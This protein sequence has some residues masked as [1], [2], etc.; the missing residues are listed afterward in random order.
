MVNLLKPKDLQMIKKLTLASIATIALLV[1]PAQ[2]EGMKCQA[3]KCG[4]GMMEKSKPKADCQG[5]N[6]Q[7]NGK[8]CKKGMKGMGSP[9]LL[10]L[11]SAM[12]WIEEFKD[13]ATLALSAEQKTKLE[14]QRNE[15]MPK[16]ME[17]KSHI[18]R[19]SKEIKVQC[20]K[21]VTLDQIENDVKK[22]AT[23]K[24][25]TTMLKMKCLR[26]I[27]SILSKAQWKRLKAL[28][29]ASKKMESKNKSM[30]CQAGKCGSN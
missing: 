25:E 15:M 6:C 14:A 18:A 28:K 3:G 20:R 17:L 29:G 2:A 22:L 16:M 13:N 9:L 8:S 30:K 4:A 12:R 26:G 11:P 7:K 19:L 10:P 27:K 21:G 1:I 23:L 24:T 5:K